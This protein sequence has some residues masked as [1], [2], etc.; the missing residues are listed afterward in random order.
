[1]AKFKS[2]ALLAEDWCGTQRLPPNFP[3]DSMFDIMISMALLITV[4]TGMEV[5][6]ADALGFASPARPSMRRKLFQER[7]DVTRRRDRAH[8]KVVQ[9]LRA[10]QVLGEVQTFIVALQ[11]LAPFTYPLTP[12]PPGYDRVPLRRDNWDPTEGFP[13]F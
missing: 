2:A 8:S 6:E 4:E 12:L 10:G 5:A 1:M 13:F 11:H 3:L 9:Y 7:F